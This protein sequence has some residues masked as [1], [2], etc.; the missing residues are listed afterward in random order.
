MIISNQQ[1]QKLSLIVIGANI[2]TII[3]N[4]RDMCPLAAFDIYREKY[5]DITFT[6]FSYGLDWLFICA[7]IDIDESGNIK[8]CS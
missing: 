1:S 6:Y 2:L 7:A 8:K 4:S 3:K 5:G